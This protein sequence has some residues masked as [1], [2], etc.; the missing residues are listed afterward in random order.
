MATGLP[1]KPPWRDD[2][3]PMEWQAYTEKDKIVDWRR[4]CLEK[5][6]VGT[7]AAL[8]LA[9]TDADLHTMVGCAKCGVEDAVLLR[10]F[11]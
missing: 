1:P 8:A 4:E 6:G 5:V 10:I 11:A 3:V 2:S 9:L 7:R